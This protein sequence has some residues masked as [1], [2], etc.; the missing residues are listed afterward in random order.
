MAEKTQKNFQKTNKNTEQLF[1][2]IEQACD[3][4]LYISETDAPVVA[5]YGSAARGTTGEIILQQTGSKPEGP[6]EEV[7]FDEFFA[8]L[9]AIRD[10]FG[11]REK[12]RAKK[13][14]D[15]QNLIEENLSD[16]KVFR[17]GKIRVRIYAVGVD[18]EGRLM[19]VAT[20]A[21]ET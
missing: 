15:L 14:L 8:R 6:A 1:R 19:G 20:D 21:V 16:L 11:A 13:F 2:Q 3:G 4:L 17:I 9:T 18:D 12:A 7:A 5:F 10:W